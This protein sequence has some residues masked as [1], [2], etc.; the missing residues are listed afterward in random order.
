VSGAAEK[1]LDERDD[2][3]AFSDGSRAEHHPRHAQRALRESRG[4][5]RE[6]ADTNVDRK[7]CKS[8]PRRCL[9]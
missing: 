7:P 1:L 5:L 4:P 2:H 3:A 8:V 6:P 9:D